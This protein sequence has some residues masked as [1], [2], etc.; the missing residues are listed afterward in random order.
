MTQTQTHHPGPPSILVDLDGTIALHYNP[1]GSPRRGHHD[2]AL[3]GS[4]LPN[5]PVIDLVHALAERY[6]VVFCSGRP[7]LHKSGG[8][9]RALTRQ[10]LREHLG[11]W[12]DQSPLF[13]RAPGDMRPDDIVKREIYHEQIEHLYDVRTAL[14]DRDRVVAM[15]RSLGIVC[16]QVAPG[17]F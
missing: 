5:Q 15:W 13:M 12:T 17:D 6:R 11:S 10:W 1:D 2:Y 3:V 14:D 9:V 16:L 4:D 8:N 7:E